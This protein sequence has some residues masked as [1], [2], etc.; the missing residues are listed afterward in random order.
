MGLIKTIKYVT[1]INKV[2]EKIDK[3]KAEKLDDILTA[4]YTLNVAICYFESII[5]KAKDALAKLVDK[6]NSIH[7]NPTPVEE[8]VNTEEKKEE[9]K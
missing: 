4:I 1:A 3:V 8:A 6:L 2:V 7:P 5:L 9:D